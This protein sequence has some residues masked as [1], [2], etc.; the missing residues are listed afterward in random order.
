MKRKIL[1]CMVE[2]IDFFE[3]VIS[4]TKKRQE[5]FFDMFRKKE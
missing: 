2:L 3:E 1:F 5:E 4:E